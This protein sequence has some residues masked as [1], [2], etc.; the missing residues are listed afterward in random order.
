MT[1][2]ALPQLVV[3]K[4]PAGLDL[5][6]SNQRLG[7]HERIRYTREIRTAAG[8]TALGQPALRAALGAAKPA[9]LYQRIHVHGIVHPAKPCH[10]DPANWYPS[11]KAAIDGLVDVRLI[12]DDDHTRVAGP[13][14]R[15]GA[16]VEGG[17]IELH[18]RP[19][20][21]GQQWPDPAAIAA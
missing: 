21:H 10:F 9:P 4:L 1:T 13:D 15:P 11:F 20:A 8:W 7:R 19:I 16:P 3:V 5:L 6:N 17:Q 12:E 14:M 18:I 2:I